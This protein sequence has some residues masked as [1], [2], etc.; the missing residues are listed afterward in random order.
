MELIVTFIFSMFPGAALGF[1]LTMCHIKKYGGK[2]KNKSKIYGCFIFFG[3]IPAVLFI[4]LIY[5]LQS[6]SYHYSDAAL[7]FGVFSGMVSMYLYLNKEM[8]KKSPNL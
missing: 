6:E 1:L 3:A 7:S 8:N 4:Y 5:K 2:E